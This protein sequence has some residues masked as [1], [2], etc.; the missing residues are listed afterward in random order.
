VGEQTWVVNVRVWP[1][2]PSL[3][4]GLNARVRVARKIALCVT[5]PPLEEIM[6]F[7]APRLLKAE[8][9]YWMREFKGAK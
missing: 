2:L 9:S 7:L 1:S 6:F 5:L 4:T 8:E 3:S